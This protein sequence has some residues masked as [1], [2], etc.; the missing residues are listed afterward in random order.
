MLPSGIV[1]S[2][3]IHNVRPMFVTHKEES[4]QVKGADSVEET[5]APSSILPNTSQVADD[6]VASR[7]RSRVK[8]AQQSSASYVGIESDANEQ[9]EKNPAFFYDTR[10]SE[11]NGLQELGCFEV[12]DRKEADGHR[13][14]KY[15]F[16]D[17]VKPNGVK[18]SRLCV[19]AF[20]DKDHGLFTAAPT[21]KRISIRLMLSMCAMMGH[22]ICTRDV[23]KAF[24]M[25]KTRLRRPVYMQAPPEMNLKK[26]QLFKINRTLYGMPEAP[27]HWFKTYGDYHRGE[28]RMKQLAMDPCL[29]YKNENRSLSGVLSLQVD[30][31][32]DAGNPKFLALKVKKSDK[33]PNSGRNLISSKPTRFNGIDISSISEGIRMD[34]GYYVKKVTQKL[35]SKNMSFADFRSVRQQ[36]AYI[37]YSSMPDILVFFDRIAQCTHSMF[38]GDS[39]ELLRLLRKAVRVMMSEPSLHGIKYKP[40]AEN[41]LEVIVC[42]DAA[43]ATSPDMTSQLGLVACIRDKETKV[44]NI[45]HFSSSKTKRVAK[46]ALAA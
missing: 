45:V 4:T 37:A 27:M 15:R 42:I 44:T 32:L 43:F 25:S 46:S 39:A 12:V 34:Q 24:V 5:A 23:K 11:L 9:A 28:L 29:W 30:D 8:F 3:G 31:T 7:T 38:E 19:A 1:S 13:I 35:K 22:Q 26:G 10:M 18:K 17:A 14:Y 40:I 36:L 20:N 33:F 16:V 21:V 2:F 6:G 41:N